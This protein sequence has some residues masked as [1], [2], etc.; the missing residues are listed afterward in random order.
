MTTW[1]LQDLPNTPEEDE[2]FK[3]LTEEQEQREDEEPK[4]FWNHRVVRI[5]DELGEQWF[6]VQEVYYNGKGEPCGYC[7]SYIGG[8]T[9][10]ELKLQ[11]ERHS[12]ALALPILDSATDFH[13]KWEGDYEKEY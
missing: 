3:K 11:I 12:K 7:N 8:E 6:E 10:E 5:P 4:T 1:T 13:N 2:A 9:M